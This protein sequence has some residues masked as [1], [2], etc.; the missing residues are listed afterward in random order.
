LYPCV[1]AY[2]GEV[3]GGNFTETLVSTYPM[4]L[5]NPSFIVDD[6]DC[7]Y[8]LRLGC[9]TDNGKNILKSQGYSITDD[10]DWLQYNCSGRVQNANTIP[11]RC[12]YEF[13]FEPANA[14]ALSFQEQFFNG[15]LETT[16]VG[17]VD[18]L[19]GSVQLQVLFNSGDNTLDSINNTMSRVADFLTT[20]VRE[21]GDES[22]S[23]S[24]PGT[25][26]QNETFIR[27][28]WAWFTLPAALSL[29]TLIFFMYTLV[30]IARHERHTNWKSSP[31]ALLFHGLDAETQERYSRIDDLD[32]MDEM[33]KEVNVQLHMDGQGGWGLTAVGK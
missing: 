14:L 12:I 10:Q 8:A 23:A 3:K 13:S 16:A 26:F 5:A 32:E 28:R 31:L 20:Y 27:V 19:V 1:R 29:F 9:V 21:N 2:T 15:T 17:S 4:Y 18:Q 24:A 6:T 7:R 11:D 33:A 30:E 25:V 22:N